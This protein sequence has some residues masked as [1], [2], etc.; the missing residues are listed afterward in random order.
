[1]TPIE[2]ASAEQRARTLIARLELVS[3]GTVAR[4]GSEGGGDGDGP[5]LPPGGVKGG[6]DFK[7]EYPQKSHLHFRARLDGCRTV[8][9]FSALARDVAAA[10]EAWQRTPA[11]SSPEPGTLAFK[12]MIAACTEPVDEIVR[13]YSVSRAAVYKYRKD[14]RPDDRRRAA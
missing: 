1:M 6:D 8:A 12:R 5:L 13:L 4:I 3:H 11:P 2:L 7:G 10:L 9:E 14:Y